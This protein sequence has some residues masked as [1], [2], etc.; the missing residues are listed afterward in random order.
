[1]LREYIDKQVFSKAG[2]GSY[3]AFLWQK[4]GGE[5]E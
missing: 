4:T 5:I 3:R 2:L 1:M